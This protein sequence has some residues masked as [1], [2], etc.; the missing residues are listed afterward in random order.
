MSYEAIIK[1]APVF[2]L[3]RF[4]DPKWRPDRRMY[5][6]AVWVGDSTK[7]VE[8]LIGDTDKEPSK[9]ETARALM[10]DALEDAPGGR[11]ESDELDSRIARETGLAAQT[12]RNLRAGLKDEGLV[13]SLPE[14]DEM[15]TVKRWFVER[16]NAARPAEAT[17]SGQP[18]TVG[19]EGAARFGST[20]PQT[21]QNPRH[22]HTV[23][24]KKEKNTK[25]Q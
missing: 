21:V 14:K 24:G 18:V 7:N 15:G 22:T 12:I 17:V 3:D 1:F 23:T 5:Y 9:S 20:K 11:I 13:R 10:L 25:S 19:G 4:N 16:T 8:D 6:P 2:T